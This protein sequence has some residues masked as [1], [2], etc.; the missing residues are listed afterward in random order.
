MTHHPDSRPLTADAP[1]PERERS[2]PSTGAPGVG[3]L[4]G[5]D[6]ARGMA[7]FGMYAVHVGPRPQPG[8]GHRLHRG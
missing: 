8:R 5:L 3:R 2:E 7:V 1:S 6:V 4:I